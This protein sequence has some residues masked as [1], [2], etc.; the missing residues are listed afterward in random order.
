MVC[1]TGAH[2]VS[3]FAVKVRFTP[4]AAI[5]AAEGIYS[6]CILVGSSNEPLPEVVHA[7]EEKLEAEAAA[8]K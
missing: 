3:P 2:A 1:E 4:P 5:S 7:S 6:G 8:R